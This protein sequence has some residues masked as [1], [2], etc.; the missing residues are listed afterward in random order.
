MTLKR[1]HLGLDDLSKAPDG[2][3]HTPGAGSTHELSPPTSTAAGATVTPLPQDAP[4]PSRLSLSDDDVESGAVSAS[5]GGAIDHHNSFSTGLKPV[6]H[7]PMSSTSTSSDG[8]P[9][10][11]LYPWVPREPG[12]W[13]RLAQLRRDVNTL[14]HLRHP[15]LVSL[16]GAVWDSKIEPVLVFESMDGGAWL[17]GPGGQHHHSVQI[18]G[19]K[20][21]R[22]A[23]LLTAMAC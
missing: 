11:P 13:R 18:F 22:R 3:M 5:P 15:R 14:Y 10:I 20:I 7:S 2:G 21:G 8:G 19:T 23:I 6:T 1:A 16:M 17:T 9:F 4:P 12:S